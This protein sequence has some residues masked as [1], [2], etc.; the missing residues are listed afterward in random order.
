MFKRLIKKF[1]SPRHYWRDIGFDE[2]SELY[3]TMTFRSL[4]LS[5]V[6]IFIPVYL[7]GLGYSIPVIFLFFAQVYIFWQL[8][9][10]AA[11]W[12][13]ARFGPKHTILISHFF[14]I[15]SMAMLITLVSVGW[16]LPLIALFFG[17]SNGLFFVAFHV[18]F[19]KVKHS[20]HGGKEV[21]WMF[22]MQKIG[23][24][25]GPIV[26]GLA[27]YLFGAQYI[28]LVAVILLF[29]G[30]IP[31]FLTAEPV[32]IHQHIDFSKLE[33]KDVR[34]DI[35]SFSALGVENVSS[36][37]IWPFFMGIIIFRDNPYLNLGLVV[38]ASVVVTF[39][40]SRAIGSVIDK[41]RGRRLLRIGVVLNALL[42]LIRVFARGFPVTFLINILN[43]VF[44]P[45]YRMPL[46]KGLYDA[47]DDY[48]GRRIAYISTVEAASSFARG[49]FFLLAAVVAYLITNTILL[50]GLLFTM[51]AVASLLI[52]TER[53][54]ALN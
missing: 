50:F 37:I 35:F 19:S 12:I 47:A 25:L 34:S 16:P 20:E 7:Y 32:K 15:I 11:A 18:D 9:A 29:G 2:L 51:A 43:E 4:A 42:H 13:I 24:A 38:S 53:F 54:R 31:L 36:M 39:M 14:I 27:G 10:V 6:A 40:A 23:V 3:S 44:T 49:M 45:M 46:F 28:F 52:A 5:M 22:I 1:L 41:R 33:F 26:G 30:V 8:A 21:G 17:I 48:P